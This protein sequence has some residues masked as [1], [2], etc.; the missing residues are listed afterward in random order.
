MY[1]HWIEPRPFFHFLSH[2]VDVKSPLSAA[3][4]GASKPT[5]TK[6]MSMDVGE[7]QEQAT[8]I[9]EDEYVEMDVAVPDPTEKAEQITPSH[10]TCYCAVLGTIAEP[11][12]LNTNCI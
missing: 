6:S 7:Q 3:F 5:L 4:I 8:P 10:G 2:Y 9:M 11:C 12:I 1:A